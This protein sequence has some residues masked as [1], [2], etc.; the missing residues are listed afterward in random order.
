MDF[1]AIML[2]KELNLLLLIDDESARS[3]AKAMGIDIIGSIGLIIKSVKDGILKKEDA[4]SSLEKLSEIMWLNA[5]IYEKARKII[6]SIS[7]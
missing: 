1:K 4:L 3:F 7:E 2:A 6:I 5:V